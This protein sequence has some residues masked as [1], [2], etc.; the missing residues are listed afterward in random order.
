MT[1]YGKTKENLSSHKL[2]PKKKFGQNFLVH[3]QTAEK[4]VHLGQLGSDDIAI[5]VGVGLG[6]L[7]QPLADRAKKVI[8][9]EIDNG[10]IRFHQEEGDLPA[11]VELIHQDILKTDFSELY[12]KSESQP[13]KILANLPYS[14]SNPFIFKLI[15]NKDLIESATI[16]LQKEVAD[17]LVAG[18]GS[19][20]Y[21]IP[22]ILLKACATT[23]KLMVLKPDQFH[24]KPKIDSVVVR[25]DFKKPQLQ[26]KQVNI[27]LF[28]KIVRTAF[29][30]RRKTIH[31]T[32]SNGPFFSAQQKLT[33]PEKKEIVEK[34]ILAAEL[35]PKAR[36]ET[37]D[38]EDFGNLTHQFTKA[39]ELNS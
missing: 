39:I 36:A 1:A 22:T 3:K 5:E 28:T 34:V 4:I 17:R 13:L 2:A 9:V 25:I 10:L 24:P 18:I 35:N 23:T 31:N 12:V 14:I 29:S 33:K 27:T 21:G 38:L 30:Q 7:T 8:G 26:D 6:A 15:E 19:K 16:M 20:D 11:N 37:L 32:L